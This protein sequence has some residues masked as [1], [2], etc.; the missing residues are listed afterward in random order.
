MGSGEPPE[1]KPEAGEVY[2]V[3][4]MEIGPGGSSHIP[5]PIGDL[6]PP[7]VLAIRPTSSFFPPTRN[8]THRVVRNLWH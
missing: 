5:I 7:R 4:Y 6:D 3:W 2:K 8:S 1:V